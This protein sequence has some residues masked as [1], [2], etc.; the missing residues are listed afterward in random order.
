[1]KGDGS[2]NLGFRDITSAVSERTMICAAVPIVAAGNKMPIIS[3]EDPQ[4]KLLLS[5]VLNSFPLDFLARQKL[6]GTSMTYFVLK[7]LAVPSPQ[8]FDVRCPWAD[9]SFREWFLP[10]ILELT[11]TTTDLKP[12]AKEMG[13]NHPPYIWSSERRSLILAELD[14]AMFFMYGLEME[15][16]NHVLDNFYVLR[17]RE[18]KLLGEFK[19]KRLILERLDALINA[20]QNGL[21]YQTILDPAPGD[22]LATHQ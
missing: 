1:M 21:K 4:D 12:I 17:N 6:G 19:T 2:W 14:A 9:V 16:V 7:Q 3:C 13:L 10:R 11:Y 18:E 5:A 15:D 20:K 8:D 22:V